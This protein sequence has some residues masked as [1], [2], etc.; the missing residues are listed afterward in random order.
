M[1]ASVI[2]PSANG[3]AKSPDGP[4]DAGIE[5]AGRF[6]GQALGPQCLGHR[7]GGLGSAAPDLDA[8]EQADG[9]VGPGHVGRQDASTARVSVMAAI[10]S[11]HGV[12]ARTAAA[13]RVRILGL[14]PL[15]NEGAHDVVLVRVSVTPFDLADRNCQPGVGCYAD[16]AASN[17]PGQRDSKGIEPDSDNAGRDRQRMAQQQHNQGAAIIAVSGGAPIGPSDSPQQLP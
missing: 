7:L 10:S 11:P 8:G 3:W 15:S 4:A 6:S 9:G 14:Y 5:V 16:Q 12:A 1:E 13:S 2:T 17:D